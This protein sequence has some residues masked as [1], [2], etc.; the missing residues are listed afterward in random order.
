VLLPE[1]YFGNEHS[2]VRW[3]R[4]PDGPSTPSTGSGQAGSGQAVYKHDFSLV[5]K[6]LDVAMKHLGRPEVVV[7][8]LWDR[9]FGV[10]NYTG[11]PKE[12]SEQKRGTAFTV[13][14]PATGKLSVGE[15]PLWGTSAA[16]DFWK[17]VVEGLEQRLEKRG[18]GKALMWGLA[19]DR[20]PRKETVED[21][22]AL[23]PEVPWVC[24][25][26]PKTEKLHGQPVGYIVHV[27]GAPQI[28]L[29][30]VAKSLRGWESS[31]V[32]A[33]FPRLSSG[34]VGAIY[35]E[36]SPLKYR[37]GIEGMMVCGY[38]GLGR[39]GGE[40]WN[41]TADPKGRPRTVLRETPDVG[42]TWGIG[43]ECAISQLFA[44]G[45]DGPI[46]TVRSEMIREN[47]Q[48][49]EAR[50]LLERT[51][52][53][54]SGKARLGEALAARCQALLQERGQAMVAGGLSPNWLYYQQGLRERAAQLYAAAAE[55]AGKVGKQ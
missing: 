27:W 45:R 54:P 19:S 29:R 17:P 15:A 23:A 36:T 20:R 41:V 9:R 34:G 7:V 46:A 12:G 1:T 32:I 3:I 39:V 10:V 6:Y 38:R 16:R 8:D 24:H 21:L 25:S 30:T 49:I 14:D 18:I 33:T 53:D 22:K 4:Q 31:R 47:Q 55:V 44:P 11:N 52:A 50:I 5:E 35:N 48:E 51:L 2:M 42:E 40:F 43:F 37:C 28:N 13:L 26:H